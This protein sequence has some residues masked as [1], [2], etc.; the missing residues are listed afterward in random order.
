MYSS[1]SASRGR[2]RADRG[3]RRM[4]ARAYGRTHGTVL[5]TTGVWLGF[6]AFPVLA[7]IFDQSLSTTVKTLS[8]IDI[9]VFIVCYLVGF[10]T[11]DDAI[12]SS[13]AHRRARPASWVWLGVLLALI[14]VLAVLCGAPA[15]TMCCYLVAYAAFLMPGWT[16]ITIL[17]VIVAAVSTALLRGAMTG[18]ETLPLIGMAL[19]FAFGI[20][21]RSEGRRDVE[22]ARARE[23]AARLGERE[24]IASDVHDLLGQSLTVMAMKAELMGRFV[25]KDPEAAKQQARDLHRMSRDSLTQMRALVGGLQPQGVDGQLAEARIALRAAGIDLVI[26]DIRGGTGSGPGPAVGSDVGQDPFDI[27]RGWVLREAVTNIIRHSKARTCTIDVGDDRLRIVDDGVGEENAPEGAGRAGMRRR[28]EAAG[29]EFW[30]GPGP[31]GRGVAI[32]VTG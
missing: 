2:A 10:W 13:P 12:E 28:V 27:V 19:V 24:R 25:D 22:Q 23:S 8:L 21:A 20:V 16:V 15:L 31:D 7:V 3:H 9:G 32:L 14:I 5:V 4:R 11:D 29:G 18:W 26:D 6:V 17:A 30:S 1:E